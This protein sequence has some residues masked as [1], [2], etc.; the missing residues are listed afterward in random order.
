[1]GSE[2]N[3][4]DLTELRNLERLTGSKIPMLDKVEFAVRVGYPK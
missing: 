3:V 4:V 1:M 2:K